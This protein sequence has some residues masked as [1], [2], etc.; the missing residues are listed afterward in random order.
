MKMYRIYGYTKRRFDWIAWIGADADAEQMYER[1][2][3]HLA[4][5]SLSINIM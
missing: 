1:R 4:I 5:S 3:K 2:P